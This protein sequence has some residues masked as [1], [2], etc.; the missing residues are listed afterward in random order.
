MVELGND[1]DIVRLLVHEPG[2][3]LV[4]AASDGRGF[5]VPE[6]SVAAQTRA[7][8]QVLNLAPGAEAQACARAGGDSVAAVGSNRK[9]LIF[10]L[11]ELPEMTRGRGVIMQRYAEGGLSDIAVFDRARGLAWRSGQRTRRETALEPWA[12]KRGQAGRVAP[13]GFPRSNRFSL[14]EP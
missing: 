2:A 4:V 12:G 9:L 10:P 13:R 14:D 1:Q 7:G 5:V 11:S 8:K 3:K 6:D